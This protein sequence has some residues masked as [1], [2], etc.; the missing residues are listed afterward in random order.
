MKL[1]LKMSQKE[2]L[3]IKKRLIRIIFLF[4]VQLLTS[5]NM[6]FRIR[7]T[8]KCLENYNQDQQEMISPFPKQQVQA[9]KQQQYTTAYTRSNQQQ[10][11]AIQQQQQQTNKLVQKKK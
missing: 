7:N 9:N 10:Q 8:N 6:C 11:K 3:Q 5:K 2:K 4:F 1:C